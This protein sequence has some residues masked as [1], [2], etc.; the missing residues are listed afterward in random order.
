MWTT[1]AGWAFMFR[2]VASRAVLVHC[3]PTLLLQVVDPAGETVMAKDYEGT[4]LDL[5]HTSVAFAF[6]VFLTFIVLSSLVQPKVALP[7]THTPLASTSSV[8]TQ[9]QPAGLAAAPLYACM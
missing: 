2:W 7:S 5:S 4:C 3:E 6:N 8:S 1:T 9:T